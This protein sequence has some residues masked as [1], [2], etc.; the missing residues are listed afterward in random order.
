MQNEKETR[1]EV[2]H[3]NGVTYF[4]KRAERRV[5]FLMTLIMLAWGVFELG[6]DYF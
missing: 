3:K 1:R 5:L 4:T 2:M 6:K